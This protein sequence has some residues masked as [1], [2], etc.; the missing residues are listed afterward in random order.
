MAPQ[1]RDLSDAGVIHFLG[2]RRARAEH[3]QLLSAFV[4]LT[5]ARQVRRRIPRGKNAPAALP[6]IFQCEPARWDEFVA[7]GGAA[8][9]FLGLQEKLVQRVVINVLHHPAKR[10]LTGGGIKAVGLRAHAQGAAL[11]PAQTFGELG[12]LLLAAGRA[13]Q[14]GEHA[15]GDQCP[16]RISADAGA[17]VGQVLE[18]FDERAD[19]RRAFG[20]ARARAGLRRSACRVRRAFRPSSRAKRRLGFWCST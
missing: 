6:L 12:P 9:L 20:A 5:L 10:G 7:R 13:A 8:E 19:L 4:D 3:P 11:A 17:V 18:I 1:E 14:V 2:R 15:D 16:Q